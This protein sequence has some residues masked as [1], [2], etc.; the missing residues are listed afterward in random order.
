MFE[1]YHPPQTILQYLNTA[2]F[3]SFTQIQFSP[4]RKLLF[5]LLQSKGGLRLSDF[6]EL[7]ID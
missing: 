5:S 6:S 2:V 7:N 4:N 1:S 3:S